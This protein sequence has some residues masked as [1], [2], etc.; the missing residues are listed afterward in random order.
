[1]LIQAPLRSLS[2]YVAKC[3]LA[4]AACIALVSTPMAVRGAQIPLLPFFEDI[5]DIIE[6]NPSQMRYGVAIVDVDQ[7]GRFEAFVTGYAGAD[8]SRGAPNELFNFEDGRLVNVAPSL[9]LSAPQRQAIGVAACDVDADGKE[10]IYVL[11]TDTYGGDKRFGDHLFKK[12][13]VGRFEDVMEQDVNAVSRSTFAGR[14]VACVDRQGTGKYDVAAASYGRPLLLFEMSDP[15]T[16]TVRDVA[17]EVGFTGVTGGRGITGGPLYPGVQYATRKGMDVYM[18]NE[19]GP[20]FFFRN[21]GKGG[22]TEVARELGLQD[23]NENGAT[24]PSRPFR[25]AEH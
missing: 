2:G 12:N 7:D 25:A 1:M 22:F 11:N 14:S 20:S 6:A 19:N 3:F 5:S 18:D 8:G 4:G 16:N 10:E 13:D 9:G 15:S 24:L 23:A 21:D 17:Q